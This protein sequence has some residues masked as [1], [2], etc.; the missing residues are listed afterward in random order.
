[1]QKWKSL[2]GQTGL[3]RMYR[4]K[5]YLIQLISMGLSLATAYS[6]I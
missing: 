3:T 6:S 5:Y 1:M 4:F 2:Y